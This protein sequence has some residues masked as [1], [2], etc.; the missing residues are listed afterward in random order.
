MKMKMKMKINTRQPA[1]TIL[2]PTPLIFFPFKYYEKSR[3]KR[4]G[5]FAYITDNQIRLPS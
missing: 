5:I 3:P 2:P 4:S 1:L